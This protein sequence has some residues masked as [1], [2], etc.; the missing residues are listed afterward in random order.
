[1]RSPPYLRG[2]V[3]P[4]ATMSAERDGHES[5][6]PSGQF[7][8]VDVNRGRHKRNGTNGR[9]MSLNPPASRNAPPTKRHPNLADTRLEVGR[10][11]AA[12]VPLLSDYLDDVSHRTESRLGAVAG[13]AVTVSLDNEPW[14]VGASNELA[15]EVDQ[16]Q[17]EVGVG[18]CLLALREG[19]TSYVPDLAA[20]E[21][22]STYGPRA[23]AR[24]AASCI[25]VPVILDHA[26]VA[27][28]KVYAGKVDGLSVGQQEEARAVALEVAGGI[29][30]AVT[31]GEQAQ[32]LDDRE[33]AM[34]TRRAIDLALGI[35]M[36]RRQCGA[37]EAFSLLRTLSQH[38]NIKLREAAQQVLSSV[39]GATPDDVRAPFRLR[40][41][42][43]SFGA[44]PASSSRR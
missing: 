37:A 3:V 26:S 22:W 17:Y 38:Q 8:R 28:V 11:A 31:L 36:E 2:P 21:R 10:A 44:G 32:L 30:L 6:G 18:P 34:Q 16:I 12:L 29:R 5:L 23:A 40:V 13:V 41:E 43:P 20:D 4:G 7:G 19:V 42:L 15:A 24:G 25:S 9:D 14:T 27:A 35:L 33:A 39:D 1:M